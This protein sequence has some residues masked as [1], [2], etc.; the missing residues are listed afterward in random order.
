M[1]SAFCVV[2]PRIW[3]I[4]QLLLTFAPVKFAPIQITLLAVVTLMPAAKPKPISTVNLASLI[5]ERRKNKRPAELPF[6]QDRVGAFI[7]AIDAHIETL[8]DL[9]RCARLEMMRAV[10]RVAGVKRGAFERLVNYVD[11]QTKLVLIN[12]RVHHVE[13]AEIVCGSAGNGNNLPEETGARPR[14][15]RHRKNNYLESL[16]S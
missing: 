8:A 15:A 6:V 9:L 1:A 11:A 7:K 13:T 2:T 16:F 4:K 14:T 12:K 5:V 3:P 10:A